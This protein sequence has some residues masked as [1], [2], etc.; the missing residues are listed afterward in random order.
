[1]QHKHLQFPEETPSAHN[2]I[3]TDRQVY[4]NRRK[5][6]R[7]PDTKEGR[8]KDGPSAPAPLP[9]S[10][11]SLFPHSLSHGQWSTEASLRLRH[12]HPKAGMAGTTLM[13]EVSKGQSLCQPESRAL[14]RPGVGTVSPA[15]A[16]NTL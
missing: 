3:T 12:T 4:R 2:H 8:P 14:R 13:P 16:L 10:H 11:A 9:R 7:M 5:E 6:Q 15:A 1:M